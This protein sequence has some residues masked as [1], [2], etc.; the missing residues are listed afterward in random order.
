MSDPIEHLSPNWD[1][2]SVKVSQLRSILLQHDVPYPSTA[3]KNDLV[4]LFESSIRPRAK[5]SYHLSN[6]L[7]DAD[8]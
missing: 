3:K 7:G 5:V 1:A 4:N 2:K 6:P 8:G